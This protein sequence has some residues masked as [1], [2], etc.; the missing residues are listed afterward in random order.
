LW[1]WPEGDVETAGGTGRLEFG[2]GLALPDAISLGA[3]NAVATRGWPWTSEISS[4]EQGG[5]IMKPL[6]C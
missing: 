6:H 5:A 1:R 2:N 4:S 3:T